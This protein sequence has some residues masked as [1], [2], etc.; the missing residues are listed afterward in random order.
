M[1][2]VLVPPSASLRKVMDASVTGLVANAPCCTG[3]RVGVAEPASRAS[4]SPVATF[5]SQPAAGGTPGK[6]SDDRFLLIHGQSADFPV[7]IPSSREP[8]PMEST[9]LHE[10]T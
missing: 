6:M 4:G 8:S 9:P 5:T 3:I 2:L 7:E 10:S 1:V